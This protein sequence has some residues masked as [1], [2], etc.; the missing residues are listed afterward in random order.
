M[1]THGD[2]VKCQLLEAGDRFSMVFFGPPRTNTYMYDIYEG[3]VLE[4]LYYDYGKS[5][6]ARLF[7]ISI[8]AFQIYRP[9]MFQSQCVNVHTIHNSFSFSF[10]F[11]VHV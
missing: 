3:R 2:D 1:H 6:K 8:R 11:S 4:L 10:S 9:C 7:L 5:D